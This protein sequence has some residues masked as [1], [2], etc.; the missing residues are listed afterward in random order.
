M[1]KK[2]L[3]IV[4]SSPSGGGK[5]SIAQRLLRKDKNI[6]RSVSCTTRKIRPGERDGKDYFFVSPSRFRRMVSERAFLE[7]AEVHGHCYGTPRSWVEKK[8]NKGK[9][10]LFVID[11]QG[12]RAMKKIHPGALLIFL[13]PPSLSVLRKR[14]LG[15]GSEGPKDLKLRLKGARWEMRRGRDYDYRVVNDSFSKAVSD[16]MNIIRQERKKRALDV[17]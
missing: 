13:N 9:D 8:L 16:V 7:W 17:H 10:I 12:G 15:R 6:L 11:V 4:L 14:L 3:L 1:V 5:T 2:G